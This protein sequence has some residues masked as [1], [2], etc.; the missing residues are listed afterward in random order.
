MTKL[1]L[2][3]GTGWVHKALESV[4]ERIRQPLLLENWKHHRRQQSMNPLM[5]FLPKED[6]AYLAVGI[7]ETQEPSLADMVK[8]W[9]EKS[10]IHEEIQS[11][12]VKRKM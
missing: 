4:N 2:G 10:M 5:Q 12:T 6:I 3:E 1:D 7:L 8:P 11:S 9:L